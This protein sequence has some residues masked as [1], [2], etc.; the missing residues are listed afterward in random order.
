MVVPQKVYYS[1]GNRSW[2]LGK[3]Y[4]HARRKNSIFFNRRGPTG[5]ENEDRLGVWPE[6]NSLN[7]CIADGHWGDGAAQHIVDFWAQKK[8][9][10][11]E[12]KP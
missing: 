3:T 11:P 10:M 8:T 1:Y 2:F 6:Q 9:H 7:A 4:N 5:H 12:A